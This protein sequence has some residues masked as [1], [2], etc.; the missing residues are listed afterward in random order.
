[1]LHDDDGCGGSSLDNARRALSTDE[2]TKSIDDRRSSTDFTPNQNKR[3]CVDTELEERLYSM[4]FEWNGRVEK[5]VSERRDSLLTLEGNAVLIGLMVAIMQK[6]SASVP[7]QSVVTLDNIIEALTMI[8]QAGCEKASALLKHCIAKCENGSIAYMESTTRAG[9]IKSKVCALYEAHNATKM[10]EVDGIL[11]KYKGEEKLLFDKL[12]K[13]YGEDAIEAYNDLVFPKSV[14]DLRSSM[15]LVGSSVDNARFEPPHT[16]ILV[17][18]SPNTSCCSSQILLDV[19]RK[20]MD[21]LVHKIDDGALLYVASTIDYLSCEILE[22]ADNKRKDDGAS[23]VCHKYIRTVIKSD[24]ELSRVFDSIIDPLHDAATLVERSTWG[25][26]VSFFSDDKFVGDEFAD[27]LLSRMKLAVKHLSTTDLQ[28]LFDYPYPHVE[29][30]EAVKKMKDDTANTLTTCHLRVL[31]KH[32]VANYMPPMPPSDDSDG[33]VDE[34]YEDITTRDECATELWKVLIRTMHVHLELANNTDDE[35]SADPA[36]NIAEVCCSTPGP[37]ARWM[38][39]SAII[40]EMVPRPPFSFPFDINFMKEFVAAIGYFPQEDQ[41]CETSSLLSLVNHLCNAGANM[42]G[43]GDCGRT[44]LLDAGPKTARILLSYGA[45][46]QQVLLNKDYE[47]DLSRILGWG[48]I[49]TVIKD[50]DGN[51]VSGWKNMLLSEEGQRKHML[52]VLVPNVGH[53]L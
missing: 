28:D 25:P 42:E 33:S 34:F 19:V 40:A 48:V 47:Q 11:V 38:V 41:D 23:A 22:L 20:F 27:G 12:R 29:E 13:K 50:A 49:I 51:E 7:V 52:V 45:D 43:D 21:S 1:M 8:L 35:E 16:P 44:A 32:C 6:I 39:Q 17:V 9:Y 15:G 3:P 30:N 2:P 31:F 10:A 18:V 36:Y 14:D 46:P 53:W 37:L 5:Q 24:D 4:L 26:K